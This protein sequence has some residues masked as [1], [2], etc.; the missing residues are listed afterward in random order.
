M[1]RSGPSDLDIAAAGA[2][3][4]RPVHRDGM[5]VRTKL[6]GTLA[7]TPDHTPLVLLTAPAGYG[8][9][10][11][12]SEWAAE[13]TR[14]FA[15]VTVDAADGD[16][17]RLARHVALAMHGIEPLEP[18]VFR[19]LDAGDGSRHL[20][21]LGHLLASLRTWTQPGVLVLDD[22]HEIRNVEALN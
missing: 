3:I 22:V 5:V 11:V 10:T 13:D 7:A 15:W 20:V 17:V 9:T 21:A 2:K 8:K 19:A 14:E 4:Q 6:L 18:A 1:L 16:P 12:L